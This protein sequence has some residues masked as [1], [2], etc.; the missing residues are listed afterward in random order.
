MRRAPAYST[1]YDGAPLS[2]MGKA[3]PETTC[4]A[5]LAHESLAPGQRMSAYRHGRC[6][7]SEGVRVWTCAA[8]WPHK[9]VEIVP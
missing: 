7:P 5:R 9:T 4:P 8:D 2:W 1:R 3:G 6:L